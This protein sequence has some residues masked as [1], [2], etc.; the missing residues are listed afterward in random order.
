MQ[1]TYVDS[2]APDR[3]LLVDAEDKYTLLMKC[4]AIL[5]CYIYAICIRHCFF[6]FPNTE[7]RVVLTQR[8]CRISI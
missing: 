3:A 7:N 4:N 2:R 5:L 8:K 6:R 1:Y